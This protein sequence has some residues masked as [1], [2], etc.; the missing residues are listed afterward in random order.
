MEIITKKKKKQKNS[1]KYFHAALRFQ[2]S[3]LLKLESLKTLFISDDAQTNWG[4]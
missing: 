1:I 4:C 2:N 3:K